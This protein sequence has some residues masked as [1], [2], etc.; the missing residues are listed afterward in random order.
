MLAG[1]RMP[2][3]TTTAPTASATETAFVEPPQKLQASPRWISW[4][5]T[6]GLRAHESDSLAIF[7][8]SREDGKEGVASFLEKRDPEFTGKASEMPSFYP[9]WE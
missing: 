6:T 3:I 1:W 9:W 2:A 8:A 5:S 7:Y 4:A